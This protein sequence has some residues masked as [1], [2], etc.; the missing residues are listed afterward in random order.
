MKIA[1]IG[2]TNIGKTT[3]IK[4]FVEKWQMYKTPDTSY[5]N[6]LKEKNLP[7]SKEATEE[8]QKVILDFL[9]DQA[10]SYSKKDNVILD[11]SVLDV[12]AYSSWLCLNGKVTEKFLDQ[13]RIII[14][15]TLKL[16][17]IIFFI[18][19]TKSAPVKIEDDG[20]REID[21]TYREEVDNI[22]KV[23]QESYH[24]GD[25]RVFPKD[26]TP[27][28]IEIFGS[29][30]ERIKLTEFYITAEGKGYGEDQSLLDT[31]IPASV[32]DLKNIESDMFRG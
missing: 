27:A 25:G 28:V 11:R 22:F 1:V 32:N 21:P 15:E 9:V 30:R 24:R 10:I 14:R 2:T 18:P 5:R 26:D 3:Y 31:V 17:D 12:L 23:F 6:I 19:M 16:Y 7:H 4:D 29:P 8:T 13:Q 20:F